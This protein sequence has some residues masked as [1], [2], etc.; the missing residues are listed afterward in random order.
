M[1]RGRTPSLVGP[2]GARSGPGTAL[3]RIALVTDL[4][5]SQIGNVLRRDLEEV[6]RGRAEVQD[7]FFEDLGPGVVI[8]AE[9]VLVTTQARALVVQNHVPE[10][11]RILVAHRTIRESDA[12][13]IFSIPPGTRVLVVNNLPETTL[14]MVALMQQLEFRHL[15]FIP[16]EEG[17]DCTGIHIAITPGERSLVPAGIGTVIDL[18]H[19]CIDISTLI[20][21]INRLRISDPEVDQRLLAYSKSNVN[22]D[23]GVNHQYLELFKKNLEL[24]AVINLAHEGILLLNSEGRVALHNKALTEMLN[25]REDITGKTPEVFPPEFEEVLTQNQGREWIVESRG[26]SIVVNRQSIEY[27]GEPSGSYFNFQEV[28]YIRQLEQNLSQKLRAKGLTARYTFEDVLTRSPG[29]RACID[30]ARRIAGSDFTV[31]IMGESGTGKE[32]LAQSIHNA[33]ARAKQPFVAVNCAAVPE[34]LLESELFGYEGGSFTGA[35]KEGKAGLFE[36][37][38]HG[39]VFLDEI[40]DMPLMLQA[41]LLRVLQERQ[42]MRVGSQSLTSVNIRVIAATNRNLRERIQA[43]QF[44]EDLYYRLNALSLAV[45]PL[46]ERPED[47]L[48]LLRHFLAEQKAP[49]LDFH[50]EVPEVLLRHPWPG[51]IRELANVANHITLM[52]EGSV[53]LDTLPTALL[54]RTE[55]FEAEEGILRARTV[56]GRARAVLAVLG[57]FADRGMKA[58]RKSVLAAL[59][60][61]N[62]PLTEAEIRTVLQL[63]AET[64]LVRANVGRQGSELTARGRQF[65][66]WSINRSNE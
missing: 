65:L 12:H 9:V 13:R 17:M 32:L 34:H 60:S 41:K 15:R 29:M 30:L 47:I 50:P 63:L 49:E 6:L 37:A 40:G 66:N 16:Y 22:L 20:E 33:S 53:S 51:N 54:G 55:A 4:R 5:N 59:Q 48:P 11:R 1:G 31:L 28:T 43:Q 56:L 57:D 62:Q 23:S 64:R 36:Q 19:R 44:R 18:G 52:A 21:L 25:I 10:A 26:R 3:K 2:K 8:E 42:V 14:E 24:D 7:V 35:L 58:G 27:L 38:N 61:R 46:R 45:P 39:T